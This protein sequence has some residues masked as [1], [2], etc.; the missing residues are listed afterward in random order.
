MN[1]NEPVKVEPTARDYFLLAAAFVVFGAIS[2]WI[3]SDHN[4]MARFQRPVIGLDPKLLMAGKARAAEM[5]RAEH[6]A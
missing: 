6:D 3:N 2:W 4:F 1:E 5:I